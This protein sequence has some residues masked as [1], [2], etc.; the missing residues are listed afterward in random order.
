[1]KNLIY[2]F[3]LLSNAAISQVD[4]EPPFDYIEGYVLHTQTN[5]TLRMMRIKL[6]IND[7]L[8][9]AS[10]SDF[11]AYFELQTHRKLN[12]TDK[13]DLQFFYPRNFIEEVELEYPYFQ[14]LIIKVSPDID[15]TSRDFNNPNFGGQFLLSLPN[16]LDCH[17][18]PP[19]DPFEIKDK[20]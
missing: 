5:D 14:N 7:T 19:I 15:I 11:D 1:M 16:Y 2:L 9:Y 8:R 17:P 6:F 3:I 4:A 10:S 13:V 18:T 12:G 20:K